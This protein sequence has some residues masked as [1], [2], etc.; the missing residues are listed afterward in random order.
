MKL[1]FIFGYNNYKMVAAAA[2]AT[3]VGAAAKLATIPG[4]IASQRKLQRSL[5]ELQKNPMTRYTIDPKIQKLYEQSIGEASNPEGYSGAETSNFRNTIGRLSRSR[6]GAALNASGGQGSRAINSILKGQEMDAT[7]NFYAGEAG[8]RRQ[9]RLSAL[10]RSA[11][12]ANQFQNIRDRNT[13]FDQNYRLSLERGLGEGIRQQRDFRRNMLSGF[14]SDLITAGLSN[15]GGGGNKTNS[16]DDSAY[17]T[18][19]P[20]GQGSVDPT[21]LNFNSR[22]ALSRNP[23]RGNLRTDG[24]LT[25]GTLTTD[26]PIDFGRNYNI[27]N[28]GR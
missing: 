9:N 3:G 24:S 18:I 26:A 10:N 13:S 14:G 27:F 4:S 28:Y 12:Y 16:I 7:G 6:F 17:G 15:I 22:Y 8:L 11:G 25:D 5:D 2:I 20:G 23:F 21:R 19:S 1:K